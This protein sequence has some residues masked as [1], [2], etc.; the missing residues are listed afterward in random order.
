[1]LSGIVGLIQSTCSI[2]RVVYVITNSVI[3][4]LS[5]VTNEEKNDN[6]YDKIETYLSLYVTQ[7]FSNDQLARD[8]VRKLFAGLFSTSPVVTLDFFN[9]QSSIN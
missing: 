3:V 7:I 2:C 9:Q 5:I 1:M 6:G 8:G 4:L